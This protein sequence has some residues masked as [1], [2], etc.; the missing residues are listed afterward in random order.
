MNYLYSE[1]ISNNA[2]INTPIH[3]DL[4]ICTLDSSARMDASDRIDY[5]YDNGI[6]DK[7]QLVNGVYYH[8]DRLNDDIVEFIDNYINKF[9]S[10][11]PYTQYRHQKL[12]HLFE[13]RKA[14]M[15][16]RNINDIVNK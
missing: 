16:D 14:I 15:R 7:Y 10:I 12:S 6:I 9:D 3:L 5:Y 8:I 2:D 13:L 11:H 4:L 1:Y